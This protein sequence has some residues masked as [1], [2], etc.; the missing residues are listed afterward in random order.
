MISMASKKPRDC[1]FDCRK[2]H[3]QKRVPCGDHGDLEI[4]SKFQDLIY[5]DISDVGATFVHHTAMAG[6]DGA[7]QQRG[8]ARLGRGCLRQWLGPHPETKGV[9]FDKVR[10]ESKPTEME[11]FG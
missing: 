2:Q 1:V 7:P 6:R 5:A 8:P 4:L 9:S 11:F 3:R 10:W